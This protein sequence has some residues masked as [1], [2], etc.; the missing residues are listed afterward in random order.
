MNFYSKQLL[1]I[2]HNFPSN[3]LFNSRKLFLL[4]HPILNNHLINKSKLK[5]KQVKSGTK[6]CARAFSR[7]TTIK[8]GTILSYPDWLWF[9]RKMM[10]ELKGIISDIRIA[11]M[12]TMPSLTKMDRGTIA[13]NREPWSTMASFF[14]SVDVRP[15]FPSVEN[16]RG[17][18]SELEQF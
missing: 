2:I 16:I 3:A 1:F 14:F 18:V 11:T 10:A 9:S 4:V 6:S 17:T 7:E 12:H 5:K 13:C 15:F 8:G